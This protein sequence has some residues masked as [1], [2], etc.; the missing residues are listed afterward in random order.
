M[1][2]NRDFSVGL[3]VSRETATVL[4]QGTEPLKSGRNTMAYGVFGI[5]GISDR[6]NVQANIPYLNVNKGKVTDFQDFSLYFKYLLLS[7]D[8]SKGKLDLMAATGLSQPLGTE[9]T[10]AVKHINRVR[11]YMSQLNEQ[12]ND[13]SLVFSMNESNICLF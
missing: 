9:G 10:D 4:Y 8:N 3:S 11:Y 13:T 12:F 7:K 6:I 5:Y 1:K 2:N